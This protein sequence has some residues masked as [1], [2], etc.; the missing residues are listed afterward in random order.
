MF[1]TITKTQPIIKREVKVVLKSSIKDGSHKCNVNIIANDKEYKSLLYLLSFH[2]HRDPIRQKHNDNN[3]NNNES[4]KDCNIH[5]SNIQQIEN[6]NQSENNDQKIRNNNDNKVTN[7][8]KSKGLNGNQ[9]LNNIYGNIDS[10]E[11]NNNHLNPSINIIRVY[12]Q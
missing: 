1:S 5:I 9:H 7:N 10:T 4:N 12:T 2:Q 8:N 3:Y 11:V 6:E